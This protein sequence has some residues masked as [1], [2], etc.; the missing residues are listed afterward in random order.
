MLHGAWLHLRALGLHFT[1]VSY[2]LDIKNR[3]HSCV[4]PPQPEPVLCAQAATRSGSPLVKWADFSLVGR[5]HPRDEN[6]QL[7]RGSSAR[8]LSVCLGSQT[9]LDR[10]MA[11]KQLD[12]SCRLLFR[13]LLLL[14]ESWGVWWHYQHSWL[15]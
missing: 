5:Q 7:T 6:L 1:N 9:L 4:T 13:L 12:T 11:V 3:R 8:Q 10:V 14:A 2:E 15:D